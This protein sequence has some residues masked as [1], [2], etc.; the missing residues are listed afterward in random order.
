VPPVACARLIRACVRL[1]LNGAVAGRGG[2]L[3][4]AELAA[5]VGIVHFGRSVA[6]LPHMHAA[7][8]VQ[9]GLTYYGISVG[10]AEF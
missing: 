7:R 9:E 1:A 4:S 5:V 10:D 6:L 3:P 8:S 2:Q